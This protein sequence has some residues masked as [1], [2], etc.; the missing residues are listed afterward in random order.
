MDIDDL[1]EFPSMYNMA[2][3]LDAFA[4]ETGYEGAYNDQD[5]FFP[6]EKYDVYNSYDEDEYKVTDR[7]A[8]KD[9]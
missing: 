3:D 6:T 9:I 1:E 4:D 5:F 2:S 8:N 7:V